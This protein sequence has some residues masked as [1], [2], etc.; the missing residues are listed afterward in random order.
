MG[1]D[2]A[3]LLPFTGLGNIDVYKGWQRVPA[4]YSNSL[5]SLQ[6]GTVSRLAE[7]LALQTAVHSRSAQESQSPHTPQACLAHHWK[8]H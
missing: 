1:G 4:A 5:P 6:A 2:S 7:S 8:H 3:P